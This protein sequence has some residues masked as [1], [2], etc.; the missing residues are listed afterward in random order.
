M[1]ADDVARLRMPLLR[2]FHLADRQTVEHLPALLQRQRSQLEGDLQFRKRVTGGLDNTHL[3][4][5]GKF[6]NIYCDGGCGVRWG[7]F[8]EPSRSMQGIGGALYND[9]LF[10]N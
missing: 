1:H 6:Q 2:L 4:S 7:T 3:V 5:I 10:S 9:A 8:E